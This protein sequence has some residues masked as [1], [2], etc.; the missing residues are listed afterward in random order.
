MNPSLL[1][2]ND[3][4][5]HT[6]RV[7]K[8]HE[9]ALIGPFGAACAA[10]KAFPKGKGR[11]NTW[12]SHTILAHKT[13]LRDAHALAQQATQIVQAMLP[14][15]WPHA[16]WHLRI[17]QN[18][19]TMVFA[20]K[21]TRTRGY[22]LPM[23]RVGM[24]WLLGFISGVA[25]GHTQPTPADDALWGDIAPP[26]HAAKPLLIWSP[27]KRN[28]LDV[29]A[30]T[31]HTAMVWGVL[32]GQILSAHNPWP[33]TPEAAFAQGVQA[34][35][36]AYKIPPVWFGGLSFWSTI[37]TTKPPKRGHCRWCKPPTKN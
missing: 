35:H 25:Y 8:R 21:G 17:T 11:R 34:A 26:A 3:W 5:A 30:P 16:T 32:E 36:H 9:A 1:L 23:G 13:L 12:S 7:W 6:R 28:F 14:T 18:A 31:P 27:H 33:T 29:Q 20:P 2:P 22:T 15:D 19:T 4:N 37:F 10:L 24:A